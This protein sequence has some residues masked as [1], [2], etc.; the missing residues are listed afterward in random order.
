MKLTVIG[1]SGS[2]PGPDSAAS[3]YLVTAEDFH[4]ILDLGSG[5]LGSLQ[6]HVA[7]SEIGAIGLSHLHPD[8]CMDLCG[9]YVAA[10]YALSPE[11][12]MERLR[13]ANA[14]CDLTLVH[15]VDEPER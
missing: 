9:L 2:V 7:V 13:A 5:S 4:L 14:P 15:P 11:T 10:K 3:S 12:V 8:H 1:C 6:R